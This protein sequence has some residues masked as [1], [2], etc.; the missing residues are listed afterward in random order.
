V[1]PESERKRRELLSGVGKLRASSS[2]TP[3]FIFR[4]TLVPCPALRPTSWCHGTFFV[5]NFV[6]YPNFRKLW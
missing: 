5:A 3:K 6:C 1:R 2:A 4:F